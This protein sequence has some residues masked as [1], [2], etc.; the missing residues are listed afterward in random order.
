MPKSPMWRF[1]SPGPMFYPLLGL[2]QFFSSRVPPF[3]S[4][5]TRFLRLYYNDLICVLSPSGTP[6][7]QGF[8]LTQLYLQQLEPCLASSGSWDQMMA[9]RV[10]EEGGTW[11]EQEFKWTF[12]LPN[13]KS[14]KLGASYELSPK[15]VYLWMRRDTT[16]NYNE[17]TGI[18]RDCSQKT[19]VDSYPS[20]LGLKSFTSGH[21]IPWKTHY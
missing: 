13:I 12:T 1:M 14:L 17:T 8:W 11:A 10:S 16:D 19:G 6:T 2:S 7:R 21:Y 4:V 20:N 5:C 9:S 18:N 15:P 3:S